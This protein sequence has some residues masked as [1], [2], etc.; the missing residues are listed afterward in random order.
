VIPALSLGSLAP[1]LIGDHSLTIARKTRR[2]W[3]AGM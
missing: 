2:Q 3:H 1:S